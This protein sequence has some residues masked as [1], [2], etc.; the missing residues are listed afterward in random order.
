MARGSQLDDEVSNY[1]RYRRVGLKLIPT[2]EG[3]ESIALEEALEN[4]ADAESSFIRWLPRKLRELI[5]REEPGLCK[6]CQRIDLHDTYGFG[7]YRHKALQWSAEFGCFL[8]QFF[9][10]HI[11]KVDNFADADLNIR[12]NHSLLTYKY[13]G[14]REEVFE[15]FADY[16]TYFVF[17]KLDPR[18]NGLRC[19]ARYDKVDLVPS[20]MEK[21]S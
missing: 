4:V 14:F 18:L 13:A 1:P 19:P 3:A 9:L 20:H 17:H 5:R 7:H 15:I 10:T 2:I 21:P 6:M 8:C 12:L 16:S 11:P